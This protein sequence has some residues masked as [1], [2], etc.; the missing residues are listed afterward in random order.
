MPDNNEKQL[1]LVVDD[2]VSNI[3]QVTHFTAMVEDITQATRM[4]EE[5]K[6]NEL[7]LNSAGESLWSGYLRQSDFLQS[8]GSH[9]AWL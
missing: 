8:V 6:H 9:N 3:D 5:Q 7:I 1:I 4:E 2:T